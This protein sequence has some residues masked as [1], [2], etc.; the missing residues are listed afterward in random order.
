MGEAAAEEIDRAIGGDWENDYDVEPDQNYW[1][2]H[3][4]IHLEDE[5]ETSG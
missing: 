2:G 3:W 1:C 4:G 5:D